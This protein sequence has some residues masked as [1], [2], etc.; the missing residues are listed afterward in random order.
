V[1]RGDTAWTD[2]HRHTRRIDVLLIIQLWNFIHSS[3]E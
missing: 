1:R 3:R 2:T